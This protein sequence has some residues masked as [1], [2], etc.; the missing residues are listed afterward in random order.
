MD[1]ENVMGTQEERRSKERGRDGDGTLTV[2]A[3][4]H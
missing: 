2:T 4:K 1:P 3:Q